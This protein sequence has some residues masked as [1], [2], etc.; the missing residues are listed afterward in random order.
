MFRRPRQQ[1]VSAIRSPDN[2]T[3]KIREYNFKSDFYL[4]SESKYK[5]W[6]EV[7]V[8]TLNGAIKKVLGL[9]LCYI[10]SSLFHYSA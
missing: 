9:F 7:I 6:H 10:A 3:S 5:I 4:K 1:D 8:W 2:S